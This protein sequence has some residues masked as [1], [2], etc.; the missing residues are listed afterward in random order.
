MKWP[1]QLVNCIARNRSVLFLGAGLSKNSI[2]DNGNHPKDW[3]GFLECG[4]ETIENPSV[5]NIIKKEIKKDNYLLA[6]ELLKKELGENDFIELLK[7]EFERP[8]FHEA[9]IHKDI[10]KLNQRIVITPNFD[11]IYDSYANHE[12]HGTIHVKKYDE[13]DIADGLRRHDMLILKMH[14]SID[15]PDKVIFTQKDYAKARIQNAKFYKIMESLLM[16]HTFI[17]IGAGINDPDVRL[18]LEN[19]SAMF[20]TAMPHYFVATKESI[21]N[22]QE[23]YSEI[24]NLKFLLYDSRDN[25]KELSDSI[26]EL[27]AL[28]EAER[29]EIAKSQNW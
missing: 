29:E 19:Y 8:R 11:K 13:T 18:L 26:H 5:K 17:F 6:C 2:D 4:I 25:H 14:G 9:D 1:N 12:S 3:K 23:I 27:V 20:H 22:K 7:D 21:Q 10:F 24:F 16:T 28:V 15:S